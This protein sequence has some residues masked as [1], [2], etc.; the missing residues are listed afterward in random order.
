MSKEGSET[1]GVERKDLK[2]AIA[3]GGLPGVPLTNV[4]LEATLEF[5]WT[6]FDR[7]KS[8]TLAFQSSSNKMLLL[9]TSLRDAIDGAD[10]K[11]VQ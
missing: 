7:P 8:A 4:E 6:A 2:G 5:I 9:F 11:M 10:Q 3:W 1:R